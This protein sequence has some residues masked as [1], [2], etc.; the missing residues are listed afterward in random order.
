MEKLDRLGWAAGLSF[1]CY[2]ARIGIRV[3]DAALVEQIEPY[4]P[5]LRRA[6]S[7]PSV[8]YLYSLRIQDGRSRPGVKNFHLLYVGAARAARTLEREEVLRQ[9][10]SN[11]HFNVALGAKRKLFVR[12]GVVGWR[13]RAIVVAGAGGSGKTTLVDALVR[14]GASYYSDEYAVF[15]GGGR[16]HPYPKPLTV[17]EAEGAAPK[18]YTAEEMGGRTGC[19]PLP[20]GLIVT[21]GY[22]AGARWRPVAHSPAQAVLA[23]L[24]HTILA[25][26]NPPFALGTLQQAVRGACLLKGAR[27]VAEEVAGT[28]LE[29][30]RAGQV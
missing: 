10:E 24:N 15:D 9:M 21:T 22:K 11:L 1:K 27:G 20:V 2:G 23:L 17:R 16:V 26:V 30:I 13:G 12:A 19:R 8:E 5:P 18:K 7:S 28:L 6:C 25:R 3:N 29:R 14:A 4:L